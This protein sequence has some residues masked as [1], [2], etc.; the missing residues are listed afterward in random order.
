MTTETATKKKRGPSNDFREFCRAI[1]RGG[2]TPP[3]VMGDEPMPEGLMQLVDEMGDSR[4]DEFAVRWLD[5]LP[6]EKCSAPDPKDGPLARLPPTSEQVPG[7]GQCVEVVR[8]DDS[9]EPRFVAL[10]RIEDSETLKEEIVA[11]DHKRI[12]PAMEAA[13]KHFQD[14]F[15]GRGDGNTEAT[16]LAAEKSGLDYLT[17]RIDEKSRERLAALKDRKEAE[18]NPDY[19]EEGTTML[20]VSEKAARKMLTTMGFL[21]AESGWQEAKLVKVLN[22]LPEKLDAAQELTTEGDKRLC[23]AIIH[24]IAEGKKIGLKTE[25]T[26]ANGKAKRSKSIKPKASR[27]DGGAA[28]DKFGSRLGSN[29]AKINEAFTKKPQTPDDLAKKTGL[30]NTFFRKHLKALVEA[31]HIT[32]DGDGFRLV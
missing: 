19:H 21:G 3:Q 9:S 20:N 10:A 31:G 6:I 24:A 30:E 11:N 27:K 5:Q 2:W 26:A 23:E 32:E 12:R 29:R 4:F 14:R 8:A 1:K 17:P 28:V 13:V 7:I 18:V 16:V 15:S 25:S 22:R